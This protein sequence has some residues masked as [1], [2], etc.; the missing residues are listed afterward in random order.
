[1]RILVALLCTVGI[2]GCG[3]SDSPTPAPASEPADARVRALADAHVSGFFDR[4]PEQATVYGV[5]GRSHDRLTD[6]SPEALQQWQAQEDRWLAEV[7]AI[8]RAAIS[9]APLRATHA[10][11]RES[12]EAAVANRICRNELWNVS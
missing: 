6:N 2:F 11:L 3:S 12:L 9:D 10:I 8:D 7:R 5:A 1:M 4:F